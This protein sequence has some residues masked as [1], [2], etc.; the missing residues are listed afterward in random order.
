MNVFYQVATAASRRNVSPARKSKMIG[1][2]PVKRKVMNK[3]K[4]YKAVLRGIGYGEFADE[5]VS[6]F[7]EL[8]GDSMNHEVK[9][10]A[11][12]RGIP[13]EVLKM[14][15]RV[16]KAFGFDAMN[17]TDKDIEIYKWLI[18]KNKEGQTIERFVEWAREPERAQFIRKY[19]NSTGNIKNDWNLAFQVLGGYD[20]VRF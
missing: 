6:E 14:C 12:G 9:T 16:E 3:L 2:E 1:T 7:F 15:E 19:R 8:L 20:E 18:E 5:I 10:L 11:R 4:K 17:L 13:E